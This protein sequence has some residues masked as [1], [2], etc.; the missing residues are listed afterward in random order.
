MRC[1]HGFPQAATGPDP[2]LGESRAAPCVRAVV[3]VDARSVQVGGK[4]LNAVG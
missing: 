2:Q 4:V 1:E 3:L